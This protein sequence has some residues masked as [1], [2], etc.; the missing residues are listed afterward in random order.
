MTKADSP[1]PGRVVDARPSAPKGKRKGAADPVDEDEAVDGAEPD[2]AEVVEA[3]PEASADE[4]EVEDE[5]EEA[6]E[7][8]E[9]DLF[10]VLATELAAERDDYLDQL[11]RLQADFENYRK[12]VLKQQEETA[13]R[14]TEGLVADLLP[15]LDAC[16]AAA[17]H[18]DDSAGPIAKAL[19][20]VLE[21]QG[22]VRL[23]PEGEAFDPNHHEAVAHEPG[24]GES[25]VTEVLRP[26]YVWKGRVLRPA[27]V[28]VR[29]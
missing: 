16:D 18:G 23:A 5:V 9:A 28:R 6:A 19:V 25:V 15:V 22:L 3:E 17:Q 24:E 13:E 10:A 7:V 4:A 1:D 21:K 2:D 26:G 8:L 27:M 20:E 29:G 12:R 11:R 14:A